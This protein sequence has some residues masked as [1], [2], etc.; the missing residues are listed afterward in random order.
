MD[1]ESTGTPINVIETN[2]PI[3]SPS[4]PPAS[5]PSSIPP[6]EIQTEDPRR[7]KMFR[8]FTIF[9]LGVVAILILAGIAIWL[10]RDLISNQEDSS[11]TTSTT[12]SISPSVIPTS[13]SAVTDVIPENCELQ[14]A[15]GT[16]FANMRRYYFDTLDGSCT[17]FI[18]GGCDGTVPFETLEDCKTTCETDTSREIDFAL[19][20]E[21]SGYQEGEAFGSTNLTIKTDKGD[22]CETEISNEVEG[23]VT[24]YNCDIPKTVGKID[25]SIGNAGSD[26]S[27]IMQYCQETESGNLLI[28]S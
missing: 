17:E 4:S 16:C 5:S 3:Q 23:G 18:W 12:E 26:F 10:F 21:N 14:P 6:S 20:E 13:A 19:C 28:E 24:V 11:D 9:A 1:D 27:S 7:A 25:F 2:K 8:M 15:P 22:T